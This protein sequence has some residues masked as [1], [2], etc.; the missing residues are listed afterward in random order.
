MAVEL[1]Q[2]YT[3][4]YKMQ[5]RRIKGSKLSPTLF[6]FYIADM[7]GRQKQSAGFANTDDITVWASGVKIPEPEQKVNTYLTEM[8]R[9]PKILGV[10]L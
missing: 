2:R 10:Y 3:I 1:H 5:S 9:S 6:S 8:Y 4:S 7:H